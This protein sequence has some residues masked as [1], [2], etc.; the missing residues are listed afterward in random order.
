LRAN[1]TEI[2]GP[3]IGDVAKRTTLTRHQVVFLFA[4]QV[5]MLP[6]TGT[7]SVAHLKE[8]LGVFDAKPLSDEDVTRIDRVSG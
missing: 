2:D 8:D 5:G 1:R 4:L 7:T 3:A 6:L